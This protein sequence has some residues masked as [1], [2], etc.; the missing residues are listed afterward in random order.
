MFVI[1]DERI[2]SDVITT[3]QILSWPPE[4]QKKLQQELEGLF[5]EAFAKMPGEIRQNEVAYSFKRPGKTLQRQHVLYRN[6][7]RHLIAASIFDYGDITYHKNVMKGIYILNRI[8]SPGYQDF[9]LGTHLAATILQEWRPDVLLTTCGQSA[10]LHSWIH[11]PGKAHIP[12][13]DVYPRL[14]REQDRTLLLTLPDTGRDFAINGFK[15]LYWGVAEGNQKNIDKAV[16]SL[17]ALMVRKN[18]YAERYTF[19]P[20]EKCGRDDRL[21]SLLGVTRYD[22]ILVVFLKKTLLRRVSEN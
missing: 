6:E 10:S 18:I 8:V 20:W 14:E 4:P 22:G 19:H 16:S 9:G 7:T 5:R 12:E 11:L 1:K 3:E 15:Q 17:T 2:V 13:F 21:A